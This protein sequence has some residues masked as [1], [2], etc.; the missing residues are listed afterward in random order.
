MYSMDDRYVMSGSDDTNIR[1]WK[2]NANDAIKLVG[3][4][5]ILN[6]GFIGVYICVLYR[7]YIILVIFFHILDLFSFYL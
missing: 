1:Y 6:I 2:A 4:I 5:C 7:L 3:V